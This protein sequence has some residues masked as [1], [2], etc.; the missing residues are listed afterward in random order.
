MRNG[1]TKQI[2]YIAGA[3]LLLAIISACSATAPPPVLIQ[4][5]SRPINYLTEVKPILDRRCVV[6]HSCYNSP[7]QLKLSS[8][9][10]IERGGSKEAIYNASR[11]QTMDP[12]RLFID[13]KNTQEWRDKSFHSVTDSSAP[14]GENNSL[15]LQSLDH[16][17]R[18]P[19][20]VGEYFSE[21]DD[22]ECPENQKELGSYLKKHPN[23]G[24]PFGFPPLEEEEF[25]TVAGWLAQGAK[26]PCRDKQAKLIK[27]KPLDTAAITKWEG[28]LNNPDPKY[29]MTARYLYE[30]LFLAH[31]YFGTGSREY[32][33]LVRSKTPSPQPIEIIPT[34][35]P[36]DD[37]GVEKFYYRFRKVHS[38]IV[39]KTHMVFT[40]DNRQFKRIN[41]LFIEPQW[42]LTP[43]RVGYDPVLSANPFASF[44][45]IPPRSRYQFLLDNAR[46]ITM[47][48]IRGP[49]CRGQ[50]ALNVI[51]DHFWILFTDPDHDISVT[52]PGFLKRHQENLIMPIEEGS[53]LPLVNLLQNRYHRAAKTFYRARQHAYQTMFYYRGQNIDA[54]WRGNRAEDTPLLTVYRH[55]DSASV[56]K[57]A[58]GA[59]PRTV[60]LWDY[61]LIER[62]YYALVAGFD[63]YGT[64]GHQLGIRLYM[65]DLRIESE[66]YFI[67]LMPRAARE[68]MMKSW[69]IGVELDEIEHTDAKLPAI[70]NFSSDEPKREL[71]ETLVDSHFLKSTEIDFDSVNYLRADE[72]YPELPTQYESLD[73]YL[74]G[75]RAV[76]RPGTPFFKRVNDYNAN[77][78]Y[79]RIRKD[80]GS[81]AVIS[82]IINRWH[83]NVNFLFKED[84]SLNSTR[85]RADFIAGFHGSYPN[86][87]YDIHQRD[88]PDFFAL[89]NNPKLAP[90][91]E[92]RLRSYGI[93]RAH[94]QFWQHFDWFQ[95]RFEKNQPIEAGLFDLNRYFYL[96]RD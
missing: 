19:K 92:T 5:P 96:A 86:Y 54:I 82:M 41:E 60:W 71:L 59:L 36:Y 20:T 43:H 2:Y 12:T 10:G 55:F 47:T 42:L 48:F 49:V 89:I 69:Y 57:G 8:H 38:T 31:C 77:L 34:V 84:E 13:A 91:E 81:N 58:L 1:V 64:A 18:N 15:M 25:Q 26:A 51:H 53:H 50:V 85:D 68:A 78:A 22:L 70:M 90:E 56:H 72:S 75:F 79:I 39:H 27:P 29:A 6:C 21:A 23:R 73:D 61:P 52:H 9:E 93:N 35:R 63:V 76:S 40:L 74:R 24:M 33:E 45:Q 65:D 30:H 28:F 32:F 62:I 66:S 88:L 94:P 16:K 67:N 87:F 95:N 44:E 80:D 11:L 14:K 37:P 46:Y 7:C 3:A 83:D 4:P 17:R